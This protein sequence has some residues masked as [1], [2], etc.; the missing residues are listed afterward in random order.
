MG[1]DYKKYCIDTIKEYV[2]KN[3]VYECYAFLLE[4]LDFVNNTS[5]K[6]KNASIEKAYDLIEQCDDKINNTDSEN[7]KIKIVNTRNVLT[8]YLSH[9][10]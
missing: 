3:K 1:V 2:N 9:F 10:H 5:V 6:F 8:Q 4:N 7:F